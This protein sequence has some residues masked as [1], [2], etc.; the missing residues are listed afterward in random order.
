MKNIID[1]N[2]KVIAEVNRIY[3]HVKKKKP[4]IPEPP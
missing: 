1:N 3:L 2:Y 4:T